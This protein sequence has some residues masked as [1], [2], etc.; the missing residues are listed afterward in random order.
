VIAKAGRDGLLLL[1]DVFVADTVQL[2][3]GDTRLNMRLDH[4]QHFGGQ[5]A[6]DAHFFDFFRGF[7]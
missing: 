6:R 1:R 4:L 7:D 5:S 2:A 3:G